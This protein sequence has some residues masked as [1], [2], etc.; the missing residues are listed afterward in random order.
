[1]FSLKERLREILIRDKLISQANFD[2]ALAEH[3]KSGE[4]LSKIL[5]K[6]NFVKEKRDVVSLTVNIGYSKITVVKQMIES[7]NSK[8]IE[9]NYGADVSFKI[10][11]PKDS[12]DSFIRAVTD[13]TGGEVGIYL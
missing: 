9:E 6:L 4:S 8:I 3:S 13:L 12:V 11:L 7:F 5:V 10:E 2:K 1:M